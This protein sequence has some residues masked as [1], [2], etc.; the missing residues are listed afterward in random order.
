MK[1]YYFT[2]II[3][4]FL[5]VISLY[6]GDAIYKSDI[7]ANTTKGIFNYTESIFSDIHNGT[8]LETYNASIDNGTFF[9]QRLSNM[10][11]IGI[12]AG[13]DITFEYSKMFIEIGYNAEGQYNMG[14]F[15][16][17]VK[18]VL[19]VIVVGVLFYPA[20]FIGVLI[21]EIVKYIRKKLK[22]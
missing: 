17:F 13:V 8:E 19:W 21:Y 4:I 2:F 12:N 7:E 14:F 15:L 3:I 22:E 6:T 9:Y 1:G 20:L 10:I 18:I 5:T 16:T 11:L